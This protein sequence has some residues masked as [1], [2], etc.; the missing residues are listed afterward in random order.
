MSKLSLN[1]ALRTL[2]IAVIIL[3]SA[4]FTLLRILDKFYYSISI[5]EDC[6]RIERR[7]R[8]F[9]KVELLR[10]EIDEF[11]L[12]QIDAVQPLGKSTRYYLFDKQLAIGVVCDPDE[13][14][15]ATIPFYE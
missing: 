8:Y 9:A 12:I 7:L 3:F 13:K 11:H 1:I 4:G 5:G 14:V 15:M 10:R 6:T 2:A